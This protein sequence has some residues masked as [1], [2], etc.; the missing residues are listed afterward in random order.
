MAEA[1]RDRLLVAARDPGAAN[2]LAGFLSSWQSDLLGNVHIW[3]MGKATPR[4]ASLNLPLTVFDED[5]SFED[6]AE[7]WR[8]LG[9]AAVLTGS[10]HYTPFEAH[11]WT[12]SERD[13]IESLCW[14]DY[15]SHLGERFRHGKPPRV[16]AIDESQ[17]EQLTTQGFS[18]EQI[19]IGGHPALRALAQRGTP[20]ERHSGPERPLRCLFVSERF[21]G[22]VS[23]GLI[24]NPGFDEV[25][26]FRLVH[27]AALAE[28]RAGQDI[29]LT[30]KFHPYEQPERFREEALRLP[31]DARL[32]LGFA[33]PAERLTS[34]L[35]ASDLVFGMCSIGLIEALLLGVP[36]RSVQP[37]RR[38][39]EMFPPA[40]SGFVP[41]ETNPARLVAQCRA[42]F[43]SREARRELLDLYRP[44]LDS[45]SVEPT[46]VVDW[47]ESNLRRAA[48]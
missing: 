12:L 39:V 11:L 43:A 4:F 5:V 27:E 26:S 1:S 6:L 34:L 9:P 48:A 3:S 29:A 28:A 15:W 16:V 40:A 41:S 38:G 20:S 36:A 42:L 37:N 17:A 10:S 47:V 18:R 23:D 35:P 45:V 19:L 25:D 31:T 32:T 13:G 14:I 44:F 24:P 7:P 30:V 2:V 33:P 21:H 46:A 8:A 22:D